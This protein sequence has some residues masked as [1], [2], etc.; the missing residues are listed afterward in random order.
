MTMTKAELAEK[1]VL[2]HRPKIVTAEHLSKVDL[3]LLLA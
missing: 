1:S 2:F 3:R